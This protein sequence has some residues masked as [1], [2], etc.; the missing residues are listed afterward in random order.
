MV[1]KSLLLATVLLAA[2]LVAQQAAAQTALP[3]NLQADRA[4]IQQ[5]HLAA[6]S[7]MT[8]LRA[9]E[10]AGNAAAVEADRTALRLA[11]LKVGQDFD[12]LRQDAQ[13]LL[14]PDRAAVIAA[15]TQLHTDQVVNN[16]SAVQADHGAVA[17]A[18]LQLKIEHEAIFGGL[19]EGGRQQRMRR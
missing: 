14:Q 3:A 17:A 8:Q 15:L 18:E 11:Q 16:A 9:N 19:G 7:V 2:P 1:S 12:T 10:A 5:D 13:P 6:Q 4:A